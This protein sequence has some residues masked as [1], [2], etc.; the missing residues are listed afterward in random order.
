MP[1]IQLLSEFLAEE[2]VVLVVGEDWHK[3]AGLVVGDGSTLDVSAS[4]TKL[5]TQGEVNALISGQRPL[6]FVTRGGV[7]WLLSESNVLITENIGRAKA[8]E[9]TRAV[10]AITSFFERYV[11]EADDADDSGSET[12]NSGDD[13]EVDS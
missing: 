6:G 13:A 11:S 3:Y 7:F 8:P 5:G 9:Q 2:G 4:E 12:D 1:P 10:E